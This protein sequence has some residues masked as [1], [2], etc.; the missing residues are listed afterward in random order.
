[1]EKTVFQFFHKPRDSFPP[2]TNPSLNGNELSRVNQ[3]KYL[4]LIFDSKLSFT[5]HFRLVKSRLSLILGRMRSVA[6]FLS[7][8]AFSILFKAFV[9]R[10]FDY[11]LDIW[12]IH[13]HLELSKLQN[14]INQ[15]LFQC[16]HF[17]LNRKLRRQFFKGNKSARKRVFTAHKK[18]LD[19]S[20]LLR[21][22][23]I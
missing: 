23:N 18:N 11:G 5:D 16:I 2:F 14:G 8:R 19:V 1:M 4:G 13:S 9:I 22:L 15:L 12:A 20:P 10:A 21:Q 3:F 6:K 7:P 17:S